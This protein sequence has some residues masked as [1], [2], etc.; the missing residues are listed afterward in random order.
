MAYLFSSSQN[1]TNRCVFSMKF[2][3]NGEVHGVSCDDIYSCV[4]NV[5]DN[6]VSTRWLCFFLCVFFFCFAP[7]IEQLWSQSLLSAFFPSL[8]QSVSGP[9]LGPANNWKAILIFCSG[10]MEG[11]NTL[12]FKVNWNGIQ[13]KC[14]WNIR[15]E[16]PVR[17]I[18]SKLLAGLEND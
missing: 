18:V 10:E 6:A 17:L 7:Q 11:K 8:A 4:I 2:L 3:F 1:C 14:L 16:H 15:L 13:K 9:H 12:L 5:I